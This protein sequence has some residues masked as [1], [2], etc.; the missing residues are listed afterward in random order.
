MKKQSPAMSTLLISFAVVAALAITAF[1]VSFFLR[2]SKDEPIP[3]KEIAAEIANPK[4]TPSKTI[5]AEPSPAAPTPEEPLPPLDES[6]DYVRRMLSAEQTLPFPSSATNIIRAFVV[7]VDNVADGASPRKHL[8]FLAPKGAFRAIDVG[9]AY[10]VDP[11]SYRRYDGITSLVC[12]IPADRLVDSYRRLKPL[13]QEA[14][15]DLGYPDR[16]FDELLLRAIGH[17]LATPD[18]DHD[19]EL[20]RHVRSYKYRD[21]RLE[22]LS[23]AKKHLLRMG[24]RNA[25]RL[26]EQLLDVRMA[27]TR[28]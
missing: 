9:G 22:K 17:L 5:A 4:A 3:P 13:V 2:W 21:P 1:V 7:A 25:R 10:Q 19:P 12:A 18:L 6:D 27:L 11:A 24:P 16:D 14:A 26:K 8:K 15:K 28:H 20:I 23:P